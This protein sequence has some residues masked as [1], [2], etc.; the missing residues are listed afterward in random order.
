MT[1]SDFAAVVALAV[2]VG[3]FFTPAL[4]GDR[5]VFTWNMDL[6]HPWA[7]SATEADR[8][9][10]TRL[11][12]CARQFAVMRQLST[13]A[14]REGRIPLWNPW[15]YAGTPFLANF[16]PAVFY[17]PNLLLAWS[18]LSLPDQM[19]AY[20]VLHLLL[21]TA[22]VF[23]LLRGYRVRTGPALLGAIVFGWS[24]YNAARTGIPTMVA[25]GAWLPWAL[26]ASRRWFDRED[27]RGWAGMA[28]SLALAGLAGFAQVFVF[29]AYAW[30]LFGLVDGISLRPRWSARRWIGWAA[31]GAI[32]LLIVSVHLVPTL[33]LMDLA[34]DSENPPEML[35]SGTMHPWVLAK[36]V[37]PDLFGRPVDGADASHLL[38]VGSGYY[39][40][41]ERSTAIYVGVLPLL[42]AAVVLLA[43]GDH[44]REAGAALALAVLGFLFCFRTPLTVLAAHL[45]GLAFSRPDRATFLW[46]TGAALLAGLG[47]DRLA[48]REG[49]GLQRT[50]NAAAVLTGTLAVLFAAAMSVAGDRLLPDDIVGHVGSG[51]VRSA[52]LLG[53]AI[54]ALATATVYLRARAVLTGGAFVAAALA[55]TAADLG[56]YAERRNV[57]QPKESIFRAP[58]PGGSLEFLE[59]RRRAEGPFRVLAYEPRRTPFGGVLPPST[60]AVYGIEDVLGFDS[61]NLE[62][63]RRLMEEIDPAIVVKRGNFRGVTDPAALDSPLVDLLNVRY[64]ISGPVG[65]LPGVQQVHSSDLVVHRNP[66]ALPRAFLVGEVR[67]IPDPEEG[68][69]EMG[70]RDFRPDLW[71]VSEVPIPELGDDAGAE[72]AGR[73]PGEARL[74]SHLPER[75]EV[76]V[77]PDRP[78]LLVLSDAWYPGWQASV[79]GHPRPI[80]RVD[81]ALR[82]VVVRPGDHRVTFEY[83]PASFRTGSVLSLAG[84]GLLGIGAL[85]LANPRGP[86]RRPHRTETR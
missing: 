8:E 76:E 67:V 65:R 18:G 24:G 55:L 29:T 38:S 79:D 27:A 31:A 33:E 49:P 84:L 6:W 83:H 13:E 71:A 11:A 3:V 75:V 34:Q 60:G 16:Q 62:R 40:Q 43:P 73:R 46:C 41:T 58:R 72:E 36:L 78:A 4:L 52:A 85:V 20:L 77:E 64:V 12:D 1:R 26:A 39:F 53:M 17:P 50:S 47:A 30:A 28:A 70:R 19:T 15:I 35:A 42:L 7:A 51:A 69:R 25:T 21:G 44:R 57:M 61:I 54:A 86:A 9:R 22:G 48:S 10:P 45:P 56:R 2:G 63:Y 81:H 23:V 66:D 14:I 82:G 37:A 80:H 59:A 74:L 32:G 68:L 5:A